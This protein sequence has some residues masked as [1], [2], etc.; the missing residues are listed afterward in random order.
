MTC[1]LKNT[2]FLMLYPTNLWANKKVDSNI[3]HRRCTVME[4]LNLIDLLNITEKNLSKVIHID[5]EPQLAL[6]F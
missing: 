6:N 3:D 1:I 4:R 5:P 2:T